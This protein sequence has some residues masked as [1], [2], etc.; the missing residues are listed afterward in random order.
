MVTLILSHPFKTFIIFCCVYFCIGAWPNLFSPFT[1]QLVWVLCCAWI[2]FRF[3][4]ILSKQILWDEQSTPTVLTK[5]KLPWSSG[6]G[7]R[8]MVW[9]SWVRIPALY[10]EWIFFIYICCKNFHVCLK[11]TKNEW[12]RGRGRPI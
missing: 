2:A 12:K 10:T 7:M 6:Y 4:P 3:D 8:L 9:R 5:A 11:K 1:F